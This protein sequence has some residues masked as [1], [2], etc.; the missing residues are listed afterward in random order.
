M[1]AVFSLVNLKGGVGK[2][3][4]SINISY[5]LAQLG[6]KVLI[7][8]TD[9]QGSISTSL[10]MD[11]EELD[12]TLVDLM[13]D[14]IDNKITEDKI[15]KCIITVGDV[16]IIPSNSLLAGI[17]YKLM[18]AIGRENN[19]KE[20][21]AVLTEFY[22]F[23][24][25]DSSPF[26]G[27][28]VT[29]ALVASDYVLIP[30]EAQYLS[31]DRLSVMMDTIKMVK[32]K[33]NKNLQIAGVFLTKYQSRTKLSNGIRERLCEMYGSDIKVFDE[34]VPYSIRAAEQTL[35]GKSL[36]ELEPNHP[37]STAYMNIAKELLKYE[38]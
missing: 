24:I 10:G 13:N 1:S 28:F 19:L 30:V 11:A 8:D 21:V 33:L 37:I 27:M 12:N 26:L 17:E 32:M 31:F 4:S 22:D 20:I 29:N 7:I 14:A 15:K 5:S 25:I 36:I 2:T 3:V 18:S 35:H 23:I 9:S 34:N 38:K 6:K 16:D